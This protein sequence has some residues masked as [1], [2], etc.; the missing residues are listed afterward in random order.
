MTPYMTTDEWALVVDMFA[1]V[2]P[3]RILEWGSGGST[4]GFRERFPDAEIVSIEH[5]AAWASAVQAETGIAP[6]L[7][8][9]ASTH[10]GWEKDAET[11][12]ELMRSYVCAAD[13]LKPFDACLIDGRARSF[14]IGKSYEVV[15]PGGITVLHDAQRE[16]YWNFLPSHTRW[17]S[18]RRVAWFSV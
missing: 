10:V 11:D 4:V 13:D 17:S 1:S 14:C 12:P 2:S 5:D 15:R 9:P 3:A 18:D 6:L 8:P 16:W 7:H